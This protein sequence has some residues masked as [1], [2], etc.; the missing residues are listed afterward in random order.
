MKLEQI[1]TDCLAQGAYYLESEGEVAIIDPL[2]DVQPYIDKA[3]ENGAQIKYIFETHFHADFVSGH[4]DLA[5]KTEATIVFGPLA[6][7]SY[8]A[9]IARDCE[10]FRV[11]RVLIQVLHT[12][13]HTMESSC[14]LLSDEEGTPIALFTGD[15]LFIGDVGRPDLAQ[16]LSTEL[17]EELLAGYLYDSLHKQILH[18][19][20]DTLIY[21]AHGAGSSCGKNMSEDT[22]DTLGNQKQQNYALQAQSK[23]E[24]IRKVLTGLT[25]PPSYF[26]DNVLMNI[27]GY[28]SIDRVLKRGVKPLTIDQF[29][30]F[31]HEEDVLLL[32]TRDATDFV[33]G[34][35]PSSV[36]VGI[37]GNFAPWVG[38]VI[39]DVSQKLILIVEKGREAEVVTRLARVGYDHALGYLDGGFETW[40][41]SGR[42]V[43]IIPSVSVEKLHQLLLEQPSLPILDV[44]RKNEFKSEHLIGAENEEL[45]YIHTQKTKL[46]SNKTY[47]VYCGGDYRSMIYISILKRKGYN[48]LVS[49]RGGFTSMKDSGLM[50]LSKYICPTTL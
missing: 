27:H 31:L 44:R 41:D 35:I 1:Y 38:T 11:G 13:G 5:E 33:Q 42:E 7:P 36:N 26:P 16:K 12:P 10:I 32:D 21:P 50:K 30:S 28:D 4:L 24:F 49:I 23:E 48:N 9:Y 8:D 47:Y 34:F 19:P 18:L 6:K 22:F 40:K 37:D 29:E 14:F 2:R 39:P 17:T 15:T 43:A 3:K 46:K 45:D 25:P 20:D